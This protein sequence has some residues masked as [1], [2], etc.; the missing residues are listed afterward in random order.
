MRRKFEMKSVEGWKKDF[1][2]RVA[3]VT[4]GQSPDSRYYSEEE[5]GLPFLQGCAE[6]EARF[7]KHK[8]HCSQTKKL[9][10]VKVKGDI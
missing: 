3:Q 1:F 8:I 4:M 10:H 5:N 7:P 9:A 2:G 6:F